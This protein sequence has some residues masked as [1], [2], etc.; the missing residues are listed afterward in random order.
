MKH[1]AILIVLLVPAA[2]RASGT[3]Y[4]DTDRAISECAD[5]KRAVSEAQAQ[6]DACQKKTDSAKPDVEKCQ[7][8]VN[9]RWG[10]L[11][12]AIGQKVKGAV[13][14]VAKRR[15]FAVVQAAVWATPALDITDDV[16]KAVDAAAATPGPDAKDQEIARLKAQIKARDEAKTKAK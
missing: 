12:Q 4:L 15:G 16:I 13:P 2:A 7:K 1:L 9:K 10:E 8:D 3:G 11:A 6:F 5:G 14:A